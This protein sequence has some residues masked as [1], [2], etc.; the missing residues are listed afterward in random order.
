[1]LSR[2]VLADSLW[3]LAWGKEKNKSK[4]KNNKKNQNDPL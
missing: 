2:K 1:M 3:S 4:N